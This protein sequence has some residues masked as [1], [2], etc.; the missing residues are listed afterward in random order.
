ML[1]DSRRLFKGSEPHF[2]HLENGSDVVNHI[3]RLEWGTNGIACQE[4]KNDLHVGSSACASL[5]HKLSWSAWSRL[6]LHPPAG[7]WPRE[8]RCRQIS[9]RGIWHV[10][11]SR[12]P[13]FWAIVISI[14]HH[15]SQPFKSLWFPGSKY[16][17][18]LLILI[19]IRGSWR[20]GMK[21][22]KIPR[23]NC[24]VQAGHATRR[25]EFA[26]EISEWLPSRGERGLSV[27][28]AGNWL[29]LGKKDD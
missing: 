9:M 6:T 8:S 5:A 17:D 23:H 11:G 13:I 15:T 18:S 4:T 21:P 14:I 28:C 7:P 29:R 27:C 10:P 12:T 22:F 16:R 19:G 20:P 26:W 2:L 25:E 3:A 24:R 1:K